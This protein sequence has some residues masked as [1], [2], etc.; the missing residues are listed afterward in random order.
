MKTYRGAYSALAVVVAVGCGGGGSNG[1]PILYQASG[2]GPFLTAPACP[3]KGTIGPSQ[4][5]CQDFTQ[6][7]RDNAGDLVAYLLFLDDVRNTFG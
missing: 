1:F 3:K 6:D 7:H 2:G 4:T 5:F